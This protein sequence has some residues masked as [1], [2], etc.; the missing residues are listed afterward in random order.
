MSQEHTQSDPRVHMKELCRYAESILIQSHP[1]PGKCVS[2][3][4][5]DNNDYSSCT[6]ALEPE[7][8]RRAAKAL[9]EAA[10]A[11]EKKVQR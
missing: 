8:A 5:F 2:I 6:A 7:Q 11:A 10:D 3:Q 4:L 1:W 9:I